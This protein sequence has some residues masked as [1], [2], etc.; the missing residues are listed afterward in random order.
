MDQAQQDTFVCQFERL[1]GARA[2]SRLTGF[3]VAY[4][5][6]RVGE[7]SLALASAQYAE[8]ERIAFERARYGRRLERL[9][10]ARGLLSS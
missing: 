3:L 7:M 4:A 10:Q 8:I 2:H 6:L 1:A 9:L 5:A